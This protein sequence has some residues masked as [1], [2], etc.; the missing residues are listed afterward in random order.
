MKKSLRD[1]LSLS[2]Q[3]IQYAFLDRDGVINRK[4]AEGQYI[5]DWSKFEVLPG[6]EAAIVTPG[7]TPA[8]T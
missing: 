4:A 5:G 2:L 1:T 8:G 7:T 6:V 3:Q